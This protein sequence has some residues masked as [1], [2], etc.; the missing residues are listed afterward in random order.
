LQLRGTA[1]TTNPHVDAAG[2]LLAFNGEVFGG[3]QGLA[4]GGNDGA[5]LLAALGRCRDAAGDW[6]SWSY[7]QNSGQG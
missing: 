7:G 4:P 6:D 3:L 2:N 5:A 1:P